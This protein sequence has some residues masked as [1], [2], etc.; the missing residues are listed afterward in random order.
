MFIFALSCPH[1]LSAERVK[2]VNTMSLWSMFLLIMYTYEVTLVTFVTSVAE[3][4]AGSS[5]AVVNYF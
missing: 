1:D 2:N 5:K 4:H 3:M